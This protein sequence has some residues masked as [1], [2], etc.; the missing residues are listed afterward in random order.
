MVLNTE[1]EKLKMGKSTED[2]SVACDVHDINSA[3]INTG[4]MCPETVCGYPVY[5][6]LGT[7]PHSGEVSDRPGAS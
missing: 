5:G 6:L 7:D 4:S 3:R 1:Q 2:S